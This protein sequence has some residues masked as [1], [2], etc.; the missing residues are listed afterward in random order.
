MFLMYPS[1]VS[2]DLFISIRF[3]FFFSS[4]KLALFIH[5]RQASL[6]STPMTFVFFFFGPFAYF[7]IISHIRDMVKHRAFSG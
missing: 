7:T 3:T 2:D 1:L 6:F 4:F 5:H